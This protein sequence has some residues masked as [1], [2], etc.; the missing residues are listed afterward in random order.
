MRPVH[1]ASRFVCRTADRNAPAFPTLS[2]P[3]DTARKPNREPLPANI[4]SHVYGLETLGSE[5]CSVRPA[6]TAAEELLG[7]N[8]TGRR[9]REQHDK[10]EESF[11]ER[12]RGDL[13]LKGALQQR[14]CGLRRR[15]TVHTVC[16]QNVR[17][18]PQALVH[19]RVA[20]HEVGSQ[21][22][23]VVDI[24]MINVRL[25][26]GCAGHTAH[27]FAEVEQADAERQRIGGKSPKRNQGQCHE[28]ETQ[29]ESPQKQRNAQVR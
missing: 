13:P 29:A 6:S 1:V 18:G 14:E 23:S 8:E 22:G 16:Q 10:R 24:L 15:G 7:E 3:V 9:D 17:G 4:S 20:I 25:Q 28:Q 19:G 21:Y 11:I 5:A 12:D 26:K 2:R 27:L